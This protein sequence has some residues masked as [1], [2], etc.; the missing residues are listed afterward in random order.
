M[1]TDASTELVTWQQAHSN[2]EHIHITSMDQTSAER[3]PECSD[4][5]DTSNGR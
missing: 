1:Y 3:S 2:D 4:E 5:E